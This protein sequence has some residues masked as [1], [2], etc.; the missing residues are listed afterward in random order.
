MKS[1]SGDEGY[2]APRSP[3]LMEQESYTANY[4]LCIPLVRAVLSGGVQSAAAGGEKR[5]R[6]LL[7]LE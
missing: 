2:Q 3:C 1:F 4:V 6:N 5:K 7:T